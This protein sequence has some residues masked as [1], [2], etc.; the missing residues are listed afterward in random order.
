[1]VQNIK[2]KK[3]YHLFGIP[4]NLIRLACQIFSLMALSWVGSRVPAA[5]CKK[6]FYFDQVPFVYFVCISLTVGNRSKDRLLGFM[7]EIFPLVFPSKSFIVSSATFRSLIHFRYFVCLMVLKNVLISFFLHA[8]VQFSQHHLLKRLFFWSQIF[9][10]VL[11]CVFCVL[12]HFNQI[13]KPS[14]VKLNI[15]TAND[16]FT[17]T[18]RRESTKLA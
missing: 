13:N 11:G 9:H 12:G 3:R 6:V 8:A 15:I 5:L 16:H 18:R 14:S 1:M 2:K 4:E 10:V 7:S 17:N